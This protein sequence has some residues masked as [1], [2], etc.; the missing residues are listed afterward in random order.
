MSLLFFSYLRHIPAVT[1]APHI[2]D[3]AARR[4]ARARARRRTQRTGPAFFTQR[5]AEDTAERLRDISRCFEKALIIAPAGFWPEVVRRLPKDKIPLSVNFCY[6]GP[7]DHG[8]A[9]ISGGAL[10]AA[11]DALP[12]DADSFDLVISILSLHSVN[13]LPGALMNISHI[14]RSDGL[15][16]AALFGGET[17]AQ[18]RRGLYEVEAAHNGGIS[19]HIAPMIDFQQAACLLQRAGFAL[20]V[21]DSDRM[22]LSYGAL[23]KLLSDLRDQ[24]ESNIL[25]S[26]NKTALLQSIYHALDSHLKHAYAASKTRFQM[27]FE[28]LWMTGWSP[29]ERQQKPL[30]PG[31]A[32][33]SLADALGTREIKL[34]AQE[35]KPD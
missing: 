18:L 14:L 3:N 12:F 16:L 28:I 13:D 15:M 9:Q 24:G 5:C 23:G 8:D 32:K 30:K 10:Q 33:M 20:P 26:R 35:V 25:V 11:D 22:T 2:F 6:D 4:R 19:P 7:Q 21:V 29:H 17:L 31:S 1:T 27:S 34:G